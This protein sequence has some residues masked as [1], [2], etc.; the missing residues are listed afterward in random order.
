MAFLASSGTS[1]S[2]VYLLTLRKYSNSPKGLHCTRFIH[3]ALK[4]VSKI[5]FEFVL[6][7]EYHLLIMMTSFQ[8]LAAFII[9]FIAVTAVVGSHGGLPVNFG[10]PGLVC[11]LSFY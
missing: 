5:G 1:L 3:A 11:L 2:Q 9:L 10:T 8:L 6:N 7:M 4:Y